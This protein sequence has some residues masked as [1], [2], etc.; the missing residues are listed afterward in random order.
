VLLIT[1]PYKGSAT[2]IKIHITIANF[3]YHVFLI[4]DLTIHPYELIGLRECMR[5]NAR[6]FCNLKHL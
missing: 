4:S 2:E 6:L 5:K 3:V 1:S